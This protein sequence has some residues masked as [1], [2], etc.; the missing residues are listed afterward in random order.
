MASS[1]S[2]LSLTSKCTD[3]HTR[4]THTHTHAHPHSHNVRLQSQS[5]STNCRARPLPIYQ[6]C[7]WDGKSIVLWRCPASVRPWET[8]NPPTDWREAFPA[9]HWACALLT[10]GRWNMY[11]PNI[12]FRHQARGRWA[13][14]RLYTQTHTHTHTRARFCDTLR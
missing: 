14:S 13:D 9:I 7:H 11:K 5:Y 8:R 3:M 6:L 1:T 2:P 12:L 4:H 10:K